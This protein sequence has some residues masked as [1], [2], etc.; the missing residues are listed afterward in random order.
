[1][2]MDS[3]KNIQVEVLAN[4]HSLSNGNPSSFNNSGCERAKLT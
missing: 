3:M 2:D 1:M 4:P